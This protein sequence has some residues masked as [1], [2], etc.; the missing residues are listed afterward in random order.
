MVLKS[1]VIGNKARA[2]PPLL[3]LEVGPVAKHGIRRCTL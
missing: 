2:K 3:K 1:G